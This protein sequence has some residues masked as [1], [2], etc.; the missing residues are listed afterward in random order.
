MQQI[1]KPKFTT[2]TKEF[3][4]APIAESFLTDKLKFERETQKK[5]DEYLEK[6]TGGDTEGQ[7][8][9]LEYILDQPIESDAMKADTE[10]RIQYAVKRSNLGISDIPLEAIYNDDIDK[11]KKFERKAGRDHVPLKIS[12]FKNFLKDTSASDEMGKKLKKVMKRYNIVSSKDKEEL[13]L[14][15]IR[16]EDYN[17][18]SN[19]IYREPKA[20]VKKDKFDFSW[21]P[22]AKIYRSEVEKQNFEEFIEDY[23]NLH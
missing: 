7:S 22:P 15:N 13:N 21:R 3:K 18:T 10:I 17:L 11:I 20:H 5:Y 19:H 9:N 8:Q 12:I 6:T 14:I 2:G 1:S 4:Q 23:V 16:C